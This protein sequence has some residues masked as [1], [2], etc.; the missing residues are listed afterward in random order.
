MP[1]AVE[2]IVRIRKVKVDK[3]KPSTPDAVADETYE[4]CHVLP[5]Q[6]VETEQGQVGVEGWEVFCQDASSVDP[7]T[8]QSL[9]LDTD[10]IRLR[11]EVYNVI[12][13]PRPFVK[14]GRFKS[15]QITLTKVS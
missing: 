7:I 1:K 2:S 3:L 15:L 8:H 11:G 13:K 4:Q 9:V 10:Q 6:P 14:S 5:R 12:G